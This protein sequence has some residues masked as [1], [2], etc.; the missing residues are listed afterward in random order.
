MDPIYTSNN[1][2]PAF[3]LNWTVSLFGTA[4]FPAQDTWLEELRSVTESDG[5]RILEFHLRQPN[6]AQFF[7]S[8]R[9]GIAPTQIIRSLKGRWQYLIRQTRAKAF[10]RNYFIASVGNANCQVMARYIGRQATKHPMADPNV[11]NVSRRCN[12]RILAST[13]PFPG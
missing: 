7:V 2:T 11:Q 10:R 6:V 4:A 3:Q 12:T 1:T 5:V 13:S 8:I 9:P